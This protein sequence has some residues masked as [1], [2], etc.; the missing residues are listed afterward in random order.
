MATQSSRRQLVDNSLRA[1]P[2]CPAFRR[3][4]WPL[5]LEALEDRVTPSTIQWVNENDAANNFNAVFGNR[6]DQARAVINAAINVWQMV[7][8]N[9]N[10]SS[11][12]NEVDLTISMDA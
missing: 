7:I 5:R 12:K 8:V 2:R 3:Q 1:K 4:R 9:F 6:A 11:G 10:Q